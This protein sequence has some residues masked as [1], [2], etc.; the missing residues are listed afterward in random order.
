MYQSKVAYAKIQKQKKK[1]LQKG[2]RKAERGLGAMPPGAFGI[3]GASA[4]S[5]SLTFEAAANGE[6]DDDDG[7]DNDSDEDMASDDGVAA[8]PDETSFHR[9]KRKTQRIREGQKPPAAGDANFTIPPLC[10]QFL[11]A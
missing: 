6:D 3:P 7:E 5:T 9:Q 4:G 1:K 8:E 11:M 2:M 10:M